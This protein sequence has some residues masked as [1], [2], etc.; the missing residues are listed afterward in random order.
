MRR[1]KKFAAVSMSAMLA[2]ASM[3]GCTKKDSGEETTQANVETTAENTTDAQQTT[4][5]AAVTTT[6]EAVQATQGEQSGDADKTTEAP[7]DKTTEAPA[8]KTTEAPTEEPTEEPTKV[9]NGEEAFQI[10]TTDALAKL[11]DSVKEFDTSSTKTEVSLDLGDL[12]AST[13]SLTGVKLDLDIDSF[14]DVAGKKGSGTIGVDLSANELKV[15]GDLVRFAIDKDHSAVSIDALKLAAGI[16]GSEDAVAALLQGLGVPVTT[17]D[18]KKITSVELPLGTDVID[19]KAV[20]GDAIAFAKDYAK[21]I[22]GGLDER[23]VKA[24]GNKVEITPDG[25]LITSL[26]RSVIVNTTEED[27]DKLF[28]IAPKILPSINEEKAGAAIQAIVAEV[29]KGF[30]NAG[31]STADMG[32]DDLQETINEA[33]AQ[34][35]DKTSDLFGDLD[36]AKAGLKEQ[37]AELKQQFIDEVKT[38]ADYQEAIDS[39]NEALSAVFKNGLPKI[40]IEADAN[41]FTISCE[42]EM[43]M[44]SSLKTT[45]PIDDPSIDDVLEKV[46][47]LDGATIKFAV[48]SVTEGNKGSFKDVEGA[49][50]LSDVITTVLNLV[51]TLQSQEDGQGANA[52]SGFLSGL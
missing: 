18:I 38:E 19:F 4:T 52:M 46:K 26:A 7:A 22:L 30:K 21:R 11:L 39:A 48:K 44:V 27:I 14:V 1:T 32:I 31:M 41:G 6:A 24:N 51:K 36:E 13:V 28:E 42:G 3:A 5:V 50:K 2:L 37:L 33:M 9:G 34:I 43:T 40:V 49:S 35:K 12:L 8:E 23:S 29:E 10:K 15:A 47:E 25:A 17:A 45:M 16:F 20:S